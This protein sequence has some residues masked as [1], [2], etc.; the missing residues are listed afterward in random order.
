MHVSAE[1]KTGDRRVMEYLLSPV[2]QTVKEAGREMR[3]ARLS[4]NKTIKGLQ[5]AANNVERSTLVIG[6]L[7]TISATQNYRQTMP[8]IRVEA[9]EVAINDID[10]ISFD[11]DRKCLR[12]SCRFCRHR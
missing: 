12:A 7:V 9:Q 4:P 10:R 3:E 5:L 2:M 6:S 1:I 11:F 8:T